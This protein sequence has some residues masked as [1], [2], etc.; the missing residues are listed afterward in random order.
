MV[1]TTYMLEVRGKSGGI[2]NQEASSKWT[3]QDSWNTDGPS[4][5]AQTPI[6]QFTPLRQ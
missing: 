5:R 6:P 2:Y 3:V 1:S 4:S